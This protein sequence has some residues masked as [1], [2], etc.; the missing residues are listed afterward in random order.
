MG[1]QLNQEEFSE[2]DS[3]CDA[4]HGSNQRLMNYTR[5]DNQNGEREQRVTNQ[6]RP[7]NLKQL[8]E[9][10]HSEQLPSPLLYSKD[11]RFYKSIESVNARKN[12]LKSFS[13][14]IGVDPD[15]DTE[16]RQTGEQYTFLTKSATKRM[17]VD[18]KTDVKYV[19]IEIGQ[20]IPQEALH[21]F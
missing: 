15:P 20:E 11:G 7:Q 6:S 2:G 12:K 13:S 10:S 18:K 5:Q 21:K 1:N 4:T 14:E 3:I 17:R 8:L 19:F 9:Q 16:I